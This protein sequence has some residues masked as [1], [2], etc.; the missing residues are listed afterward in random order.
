MISKKC[1]KCHHRIFT[2]INF[3]IKKIQNKSVPDYL[4]TLKMNGHIFQLYQHKSQL[5]NFSNYLHLVITRHGRYNDYKIVLLIGRATAGGLPIGRAG[6][7][8]KKL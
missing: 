5:L 3:L 4:K 1:L 7:L 6:Y 8:C 2:E